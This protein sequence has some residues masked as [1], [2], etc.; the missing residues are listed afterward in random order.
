MGD[1]FRSFVLSS[2]AIVGIAA[3]ASCS[4]PGDSPPGEQTTGAD[5]P[6]FESVEEVADR[7]LFAFIGVVGEGSDSTLAPAYGS[8]SPDA[9]SDRTPSPEETEEVPVIEYPV[10]VVDP[11]SSLLQ[12]GDE[13]SVVVAGGEG[14]ESNIVSLE[15]DEEYLFF[16]I[17]ETEDASYSLVGIDVGA[18]QAQGDG[19][20]INPVD[21]VVEA[22]ELES[23]AERAGAVE[24]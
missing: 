24:G 22:D 23:Y 12:Q 19:S 13:T 21:L 6:D 4:S 20:Y 15:R 7:S 11:L 18:F 10:S 1:S 5:R 16:V 8:G 14:F 2:A 3:L 17:T 9:G